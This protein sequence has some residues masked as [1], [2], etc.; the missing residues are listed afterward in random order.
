MFKGLMNLLAPVSGV[1]SDERRD[2]IRLTCSI[3]V[4]M[5]AGG[6]SYP[7]TVVNVSLTGLCLELDAKIKAQ[8]A[9]VLEREEFGQP[10]EGQAVWCR[11][12]RNNSKH[13]VGVMYKVDQQ[14]LRASWL[15]PALK[16]LGFK[17][18]MI[19]E[20][21]KLLRV[22]GQLECQ[23]KGMTGDTYTHGKMLDL[24]VG[25]AL[26]EGEV[27]LP[28]NLQIQFEIEPLGSLKPLEGV[29]RVVNCYRESEEENWRCG[30]RF[31]EVDDTLVRRYLKALMSAR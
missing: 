26:V 20:K 6:K 3:D 7:A 28:E 1:P 16:Q 17:S 23:L 22:P 10:L 30:I 31:T 29:A 19:S 12:S 9:V 27:E 15:T 8:Q 13:Q 25:G 24:S 11:S 5:N 14:M 18:E 4:A 21:R 2:T